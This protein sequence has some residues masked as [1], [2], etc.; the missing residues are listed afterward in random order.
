MQSA[1][2]DQVLQAGLPEEDVTIV[3]VAEGS[4]VLETNEWCADLRRHQVSTLRLHPG[5]ARLLAGMLSRL[6]E[7]A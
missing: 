3:D 4:V 7:S 2:V 6:A 1:A 5:E